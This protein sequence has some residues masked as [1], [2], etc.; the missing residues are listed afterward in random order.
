[1]STKSTC[2]VT[3]VPGCGDEQRAGLAFVPPA[4]RMS[5]RTAPRP[6]R[7]APVT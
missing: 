2:V 3:L 4:R 7:R 1:M 6:T 5:R